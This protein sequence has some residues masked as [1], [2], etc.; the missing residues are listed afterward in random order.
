[1]EGGGR[2]EGGK[3]DRQTRTTRH[4]SPEDERAREGAWEAVAGR[5]AGGKSS[6]W[7]CSLPPPASTCDDVMLGTLHPPFRLRSE[8]D[9]AAQRARRLGNWGVGLGVP[10]GPEPNS[11]LRATCGVVSGPF[12]SPRGGL[13]RVHKT[14]GS[15]ICRSSNVHISFVLSFLNLQG[16]RQP[17][18]VGAFS[19]REMRKRPGPLR[20]PHWRT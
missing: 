14:N 6:C 1:M 19:S 7:G 5:R 3:E 18:E 12:S 9:R 15:D 16:S 10:A 20:R 8:T 2:R 11:A 13:F 4:H 17:G